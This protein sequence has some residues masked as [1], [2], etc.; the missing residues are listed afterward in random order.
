MVYSVM[1]QYMCIVHNDQIIVV[2]ISISSNFF[3]FLNLTQ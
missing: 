1:I 3:N 2:N